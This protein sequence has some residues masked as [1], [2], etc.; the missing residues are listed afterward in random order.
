MK[1]SIITIFKIDNKTFNSLEEVNKYLPE[2]NYRLVCGKNY[3]FGCFIINHIILEKTKKNNH[4][5]SQR[6]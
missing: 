6:Y 5:R 1:K 3:S 2:R 4:V